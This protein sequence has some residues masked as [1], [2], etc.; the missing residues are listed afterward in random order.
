[1]TTETKMIDW[2]KMFEE[3]ESDAALL[4]EE[5][6]K[7]DI[8]AIND[9][10]EAR[11]LEL[12]KNYD[13]NN[14]PDDRKKANKSVQ[15]MRA[16]LESFG[17]EKYDPESTLGS[18]EFR[19]VVMISNEI[20]KMPFNQKGEEKVRDMIKNLVFK[21][22]RRHISEDHPKIQ[23]LRQLYRDTVA[24]NTLKYLNGSERKPERDTAVISRLNDN[25]ADLSPEV[26]KLVD[27]QKA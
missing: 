9:R 21:N 24:L 16:I 8:I 13:P 20:K 2:N 11:F 26:Q 5:L 12:A 14:V 25:Y 10:V 3:N 23:G 7:D 19:S 27:A 15:N 6:S 18:D 17:V 4:Q 1:M 22:G